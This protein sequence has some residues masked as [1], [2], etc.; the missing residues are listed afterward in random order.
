M[1]ALVIVILTEIENDNNTA[2]FKNRKSVINDN[3]NNTNTN[4]NNYNDNN[5]SNNN[6]N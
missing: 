1:I 3:T 4:N 2:F 5:K 6:N